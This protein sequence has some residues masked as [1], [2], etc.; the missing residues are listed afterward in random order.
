MR[1]KI[2]VLAIFLLS[3]IAGSVSAENSMIETEPTESF[4]MWI[5]ATLPGT[6]EA[7]YEAITGDVSG[8]WAHT[9]EDDPMEV[10]V[11][12]VPGGKFTE[13][14]DEYGSGVQYGTVTQVEYGQLLQYEG[15][16][17]LDP[18]A[19]T[20][21]TTWSLNDVEDGQTRVSIMVRGI[22]PTGIGV[23]EKLERKWDYLLNGTLSP[24][25]MEM[26]Q[27]GDLG[28]SEDSEDADAPP[29]ASSYQF[30]LEAEIPGTP[31]EVFD[32]ATGD[33]SGWWDHTFSENP[34]KLTVD[35]FPGGA[36]MEIF[37]DEGNGARH[38]VVTAADRGKLLRYEG[39]LGLAGNAMFMVTT[40]TFAEW[41]DDATLVTVEV[42]ASGEIQD[43]WPE[44]IEGVWEHFL[45][46]GLK[47]YREA[48]NK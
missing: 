31:N 45:F 25:L 15:P 22:C 13:T 19:L 8:W 26:G 2:I 28:Y 35:P 34:K 21:T 39:P 40:W 20:M 30:T 36:F 4:T 23:P 42:H 41:G 47:A 29:A 7:V 43:G 11:D 38:A 14:W 24:Y 6:S 44:V 32:S 16:Y 48:G 17:I 1:T 10:F 12:A 5:E 37:D 46:E 33:I 9:R 18:D 3:G 27:S